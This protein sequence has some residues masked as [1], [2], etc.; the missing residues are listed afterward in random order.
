MRLALTTVRHD[1]MVIAAGQSLAPFEQRTD[2]I[3]LL[4]VLGW[5][6]ALAVL[7]AGATVHVV[8]GRRLDRPAPV[9]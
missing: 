6:V 2:R 1:Q 5:L 8:V 3:G 4:L 9:G 7:T